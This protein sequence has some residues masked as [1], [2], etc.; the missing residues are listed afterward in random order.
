MQTH[1]RVLA[2][3]HIVFGAMGLVAGI[4]MLV[5]FGGLAGLAAIN[6]RSGD[7]AAALPILGAIGGLIFVLALVLSLP[8]IIA[9]VGLINYRPWARILAIV[10]S[11]LM[12]LQLPFGT[13]LGFYGLWVLLSAEGAALFG[14]AR[15]QSPPYLR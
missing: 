7:A 9:G 2:V 13:A 10:L 3:L 6:D 12:L 15:P 4:G 1:V 11:V 8:E 14:A 5:L